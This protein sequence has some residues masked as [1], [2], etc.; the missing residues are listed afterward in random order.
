MHIC[1]K[2][3]H[4]VFV[5][6]Q[7]LRLRLFCTYGTPVLKTLDCWPALPIVVE[8]GGSPALSPPAPEDEDNIVAALRRS[9]RVISIHL[10]VTL[11]LLAKLY[12]IKGPFS[13]LEDLVILSLDDVRLTFPSSFRWGPHL[14]TFHLTR[15]TFPTLPWLLFSSKDLVDIQLHEVPYISPESLWNAFSG[16]TQLRLLSLS[17]DSLHSL[18]SACA[19]LV[20]WKRVVL[21]TLT[22]LKYW[23]TSKCLDRLVAGVDAPYL[24][25]LEI[26][27]FDE[28]V[29]DVTNLRRFI[30]RI[31]V[32]K[33]HLQADI[34]FSERSISI[35]LTKSLT[36]SLPSCLKLQVTC[37][38]SNEQVLSIFRSFSTFFLCVEDLR[39]EARSLSST[40]DGPH[41]RMEVI[42]LF[43]ATK[44][45]HIAGDFLIDIVLGLYTLDRRRETVLPA[46]EKLCIQGPES[47]IA[48]LRTAVVSFMV[49]RRLSGHP[50]AVEYERPWANEIGIWVHLVPAPHAYMLDQDLMSRPQSS[51]YPKTSYWS[52]SF[53]VWILVQSFGLR[54]RMYAES[55]V[56]SY[57]DHPEFYIFACTVSVEGLSRGL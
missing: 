19:Y 28:I 4:V 26:T 30:D 22:C 36:P 41:R 16:M 49:L 53:I 29:Y 1:R 35:S 15:I 23:G 25:D 43:R 33:S 56:R 13:N 40:R 55:G 21:P 51:R 3:R 48:P 7:A 37:E 2:W 45:F 39:I 24:E 57:I 12:S 32:Q 38:P 8:Y 44:Q 34:L 17:F 5:S 6:R 54:S 50:I 14:R 52:F 42:R 9:D 11:S 46:M 20:P 18:S 31:E 10:T 27:F 47:H